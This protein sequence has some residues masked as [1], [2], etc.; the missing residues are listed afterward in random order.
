MTTI[1]DAGQTALTH[2]LDLWAQLIV[3]PRK[4]GAEPESAAKIDRMIRSE[5]GL[6]WSWS[7]PFDEGSDYEWC[8]AFAAVCWARAGLALDL[9]RLYWS[10]TARLATYARYGQLFGTENEAR[11]RA[12][13]P[14]PKEGARLS[15]VLDER[16]TPDTLRQLGVEPQP[17]DVLL[18]GHPGSR[19][20][21]HVTLVESYDPRTASFR[22]VE[23]NARGRWPDG[24]ARP[25]TQG[26]VKQTRS[27]GSAADGGYHARRLIRP[28]LLDLTER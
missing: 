8:G 23:G 24:K 20:G 15:V 5:D 17:G 18:V 12:Q 9:R 21:T 27:L 28:S 1:A 19:M 26:V 10:S 11:I 25:S 6:G 16:S 2:A 7:E 3:E 14:R 13:Y 4:R 22:T